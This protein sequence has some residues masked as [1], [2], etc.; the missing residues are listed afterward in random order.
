MT[1][2][3]S[4]NHGG[5][6]ANEMKPPLASLSPAE[7]TAGATDD[8]ADF[9]K[10]DDQADE[11]ALAKTSKTCLDAA[12]WLAQEDEP[13]TPLVEGLIECGEVVA[14]VGQSKA[15]K[16]HLALQLAVCVATGRDFI[17][18]KCVRKRVYLSNLEISAKQYKKRFRRTCKALGIMPEDLR[19]WLFV[20]NM[21][22]E[23]ATWDNALAMCRANECE[24]AVIDPFYQIAKI[25]ENDQV[26]C[27][28]EVEQMKPFTKAGVALIIVFHSPKGFSGDRQL[29]DMISGSAIL[30]RFPES[31]IGLLNHATE[32][33]ARVVSAILRNYPPFDPF[34]VTLEDGV[35]QSAQDISP[36]VATARNASLRTKTPGANADENKAKRERLEKAVQEFFEIKPAL[37][38][39]SFKAAIRETPAGAAYGVNAIGDAIKV[40][41][42]RG[43]LKKTDA[44]EVKPD[45]SVGRPKER[46][47]MIGTPERIEAY[48]EAFRTKTRR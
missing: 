25:N 39:E 31:I 24:V 28:A 43:I 13:D 4:K 22:G 48:A 18:R 35:F 15:G 33:T 40:M 42:Q 34:A 12:D 1:K 17:G 37:S 46:K 7:Q 20:D 27:L 32:K 36:E 8:G 14:L 30:A 19:G 47:V 16:S 21:R 29:I 10:A 6:S 44:L 3:L 23:S 5:T 9:L 2:G 38:V 11:I 26:E 45:G 41:V